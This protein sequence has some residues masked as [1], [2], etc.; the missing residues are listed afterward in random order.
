MVGEVQITRLL[1][2]YFID[3]ETSVQ[4]LEEKLALLDAAGTDKL[5]YK[6]PEGIG[7]K[8]ILPRSLYNSIRYSA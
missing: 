6:L 5:G 8:T 4:E 3:L 7:A 2:K 1:S